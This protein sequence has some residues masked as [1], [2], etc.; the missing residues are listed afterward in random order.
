MKRRFQ[1]SLLILFAMTMGAAYLWPVIAQQKEIPAERAFKNIQSLKGVPASQI[2]VLMDNFSK[3][4]GVNCEYCHVPNALE[5]GDKREHKMTVQ[6]IKMTRDINQ[7]Y[8]ISIDCMACHQGKTKPPNLGKS[9]NFGP[10]GIGSGGG[11]DLT[12]PVEP[13]KDEPKPEAEPPGKVVF[14]ASYGNVPFDHSSHMNASD[15]ATC[16]HTGENNKCSTCHQKA[17]SQLSK[18]TS[19]AASHSATSERGCIGC[20][21]KQKA[22]PTKCNDCHKK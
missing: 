11:T 1:L 10:N 3:A 5:K 12:Q 9:M 20:H 14:K 4:L 18:I 19:K 2:T 6:M 21:T 15:C 7:R 16:H 13:K 8:Q 22:G 17:P